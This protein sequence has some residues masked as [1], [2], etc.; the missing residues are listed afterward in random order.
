MVLLGALVN[1]LGILIGS[2]IGMKLHNIPER[3]KDTVMKGMGLSVIVLG[4]QMA[5]KTSNSLIVI[6]SICFGAVIGEWLNIDYHLNQL[7][8]WIE[9]KVGAKGKSNVSKGFVTATL[10]FVIGAMGII[11]ALDSGIRGNHDDVSTLKKLAKELQI[12]ICVRISS[13]LNSAIKIPS[14]KS[15]VSIIVLSR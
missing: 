4:I 2:V 14:E 7:G 15:S 10:I 8:H 12:G 11:G 9:R 5:F 6:L 3:M 1:G 13:K